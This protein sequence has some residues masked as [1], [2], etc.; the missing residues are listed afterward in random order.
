MQ[1]RHARR[2]IHHVCS[3]TRGGNVTGMERGW[4]CND[5]RRTTVSHAGF[6]YPLARPC[7]INHPGTILS[8]TGTQFSRARCSFEFRFP[9]FVCPYVRTRRSLNSPSPLGVP[10]LRSSLSF[11]PR[12]IRAIHLSSLLCT[13]ALP[14]PRT[15]YFVY[16]SLVPLCRSLR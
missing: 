15:C 4:S 12:L 11:L 14:P 10:R 13:V 9:A 3:C 8:T 7:I 1:S 2:R 16:F 6:V 5:E